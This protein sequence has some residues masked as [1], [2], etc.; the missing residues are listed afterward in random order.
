MYALI[1]N[2]SP[3]P[4]AFT[5]TTDEPVVAVKSVVGLNLT[6]FKNT[7]IEPTVYDNVLLFAS[8]PVNVVV[9]LLGANKNCV[10]IPL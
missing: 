4:A 1:C 7:S 5:N 8:L 3:L 9:E 6:P 2:I 10:S